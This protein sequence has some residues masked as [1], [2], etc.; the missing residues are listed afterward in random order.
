MSTV[1][2]VFPVEPGA[3]WNALPSGLAAVKGRSEIYDSQRGLLSF[4]TG[5]TGLTWGLEFAAQVQPGPQGTVL[6]VTSNLK[7]GFIDWG[8]GKRRATKFADAVGVAL[9]CRFS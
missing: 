2:K 5:M 7:M 3:V 8:E 1:Q 9:G 6:S 4:N